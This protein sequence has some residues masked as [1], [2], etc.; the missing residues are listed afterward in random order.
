MYVCAHVYEVWTT[1][2]VYVHVCV[3]VCV[4]VCVHRTSKHVKKR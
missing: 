2:C 4:C 3:C 1:V